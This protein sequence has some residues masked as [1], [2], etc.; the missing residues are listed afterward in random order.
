M[1]ATAQQTAIINLYTALFDRAPDA[2]GLNFWTQALIDGASLSTITQSFLGTPEAQTIYPASQTSEQFISAFY[3]AVFGRTADAG[4]LKFWTDALNAAGGTDSEAAK[5]L[6]VS[7]IN[8]IVSTPLSIKPA[9]LS[10]AEYAETLADRAT[11]ANKV[12]VGVYFAVDTKSNDLALAKQALA[13]VTA[14]AASVDAAKQV[15]DTPAGGTP[16]VPTPPV[17]THVGSEGN[18]VFDFTHLNVKAGD[19]IDGLGGNDTLNYIDSSTTGVTF[20]A[21]T[22]RNVET[23]NIRNMNTAGATAESVYFYNLQNIADGQTLTVAGVTIT[24]NG[25]ATPADI[26]TAIATGKSVGNAIY[27][28]SLTG[29]QATQNGN[30]ITFL[31]TVKGNVS[32]LT[33]S[34]LGASNTFMM[35]SQG[36]H[37][38]LDTVAATSFAGATLFNSDRSIAA[39]AFDGLTSGQTVGL[40]G[41][42]VMT[43]KN[44]SASYA[45]NVT[46]ATVDVSGGT[47]GGMV[48]LNGNGLTQVVINSVDVANTLSGVRLAEATTS[49][50]INADASLNAAGINGSGLKT[51][52]V[53]GDAAVVDLGAVDSTVL[54]SIDASGL[55]VGGV[56]AAIDAAPGADI[57]GG[58]GNDE[59]S[60][61][62]GAVITGTIDGG[63]GGADVIGFKSSASLTQATAMLISNVEVARFSADYGETETYDVS[64]VNGIDALQVADGGSVV[65]NNVSTAVTVVG[66]VSGSL[67]LNLDTDDDLVDITLHNKFGF[68]TN[69]GASPSTLKVAGIETLQVHSLSTPTGSIVVSPNSFSNDE[70]NTSLSLVVIDGNKD[71][72][73]DTGSLVDGVALT[74][75]AGNA[76]G[77]ITL[78]SNFASKHLDVTGGSASDTL[79]LGTAGSSVFGGKGGDSIYLAEDEL[80]VDLVKYTSG[81]ESTLDVVNEAGT[82]AGKMDS[83]AGF[84]SGTDKIDL[85]SLFTSIDVAQSFFDKNFDTIGQ[86]NAENDNASF[87][88]DGDMEH[89]AIAAHIGADTY[90]VVDADQNGIFSAATDLVIKLAGVS[91]LQQDDLLLA[92]DK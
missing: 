31:S 6:V 79:F 22:V 56:V 14:D 24:A 39:V 29:Y 57:K 50:H 12:A 66:T 38:L 46:V 10:D 28:G 67:T 1:A 37:G 36:Q 11:F 64:L 13:G 51:I 91:T 4:G 27:S 55:S 87:Y 20:P 47:K 58:A 82:V 40:I 74:I 54:A 60:I 34:G 15:I 19:V 75:D 84:Q 61:K 85:I 69:F 35:Y 26:A 5:A 77:A 63:A 89:I 90:L 65:L 52:V 23:I 8:E 72:F 2:D 59:I 7:Q 18:D 33:A 16:T 81:S 73:F 78:I 88:S 32:D 83:I 86:L 71:L 80:G 70:A 17:A 68:G 25:V 44:L 48:T 9:N 3:Q 45:S 30:T 43:T 92:V 41:D 53:S 62:A 76:T 42:G 49:L 21:A